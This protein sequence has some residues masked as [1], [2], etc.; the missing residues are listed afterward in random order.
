M[1]DL[2]EREIHEIIERSAAGWM[3]VGGPRP[4]VGLRAVAELAAVPDGELGD[5]IHPTV[6]AAVARLP[7]P[8]RPSVRRVSKDA[9]SSST[10]CGGPCSTTPSSSPGW[11]TR[12]RTSGGGRQDRQEPP[13]RIQGPR[14]RGSRGPGRVRRRPD[15]GHRVRAVRDRG[16]HHPGHEPDIGRSSTT[17]QHRVGRERGRLQCAPERETLLRRDSPSHQPGGLSARRPTGPR[18][19]RRTPDHQTARRS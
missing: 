6:D 10:P 13:R 15:D 2:D 11:P 7:A 3:P 12:R 4:G 18:R 19:G 9:R 8:S 1:S 5:G 16:V 14:P 17:R